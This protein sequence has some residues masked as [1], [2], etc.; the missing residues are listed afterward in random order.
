MPWLLIVCF[1]HEVQENEIVPYIDCNKESGLS[2]GEFRQGKGRMRKKVG[3][4]G[5][6]RIFDVGLVMNLVIVLCWT[7]F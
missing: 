2:G 5:I 7:N 6:C 3:R 1:G 4:I